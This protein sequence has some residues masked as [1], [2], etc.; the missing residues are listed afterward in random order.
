M[1]VFSSSFMKIRHQHCFSDHISSP[2][3]NLQ[4]QRLLSASTSPSSP[5]YLFSPLSQ[6]NIFACCC[7]GH[8]IKGQ[9]RV[10]HTITSCQKP[11]G[12]FVIKRVS[13]VYLLPN[14][15]HI[16]SAAAHSNKCV[17][18]GHLC[19]PHPSVMQNINTDLLNGHNCGL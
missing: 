5:P 8:C 15:M 4:R 18:D 14:N 10:R 6:S 1:N 19:F 11:C 9:I 3:S 16:I 13:Y 7:H 2:E 12:G 17:I